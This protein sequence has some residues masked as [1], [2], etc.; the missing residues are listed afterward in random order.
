MSY[1]DRSRASDEFTTRVA[2]LLRLDDETASLLTEA[3]EELIRD[4]VLAKHE[5]EYYHNLRPEY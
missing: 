2:K 1:A 3:I 4:T 5:E